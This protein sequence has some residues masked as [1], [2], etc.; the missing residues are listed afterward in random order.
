MLRIVFWV[1]LA[2][3]LAWVAAE[4]WLQIRQRLRSGRTKSTEWRSFGVIFL[5][6]M[7]GDFVAVYTA[8]HLRVLHLP[9]SS[10]LFVAATVLI[11][12]G[13]GFRLWAIR[14]LGQ[15]FRAVVHVQEGHKVVRS[16]PYRYLRHPSYTGLLV[17]L[18]GLGLVFTNVVSWV[19]FVCCA[20]AS[21]LYRIRVEERVLNEALGNEYADYAAHTKR[22]VPGV[23]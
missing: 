11:W 9:L 14:T 8:H 18:V 12:A 17:A 15:F 16:G 13:A 5:S 21:I 4:M 22:L 10:G 23:W 7:A 2:S 20:V 6:I 3:V 19:I 1:F